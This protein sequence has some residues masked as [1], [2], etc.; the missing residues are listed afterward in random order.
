MRFRHILLAAML[1]MAAALPCAARP[2]IT[3]RS[4][5]WCPYNCTPGSDHPGYAVEIAQI[6][7]GEAGYDVDYQL[8]NWTRSI[9]EARQGTADAVIGAYQTDVPGFA[10]PREPI[11]RSSAGFAV[12]QQD[13]FRYN[14]PR[15]LDGHVLGVVATYE[16]AGPLGAYLH[17]M[18]GD[19]SRVQS[20]S[21]DGALAKNLQKLMA[22]RLDVVIDDSYV[23]ARTIKELQLEDRV[24]LSRDK[25]SVA[26]YVA[27]SPANKLSPLFAKL[28]TDG[29]ARLRASGRLAEILKRYGVH[30]WQ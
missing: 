4:D 25:T 16:F 6:V 29:I 5:L 12:R 24:S 2:L 8:L 19:R 27:F 30:D 9:E 10:I 15:S 18:R 14:G 3:L 11:G 28:L 20:M 7:F 1:T 22:G 21:G 26:V 13:P 17:E 23:L